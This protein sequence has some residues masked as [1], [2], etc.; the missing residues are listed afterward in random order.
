MRTR[1]HPKFE[2]VLHAVSFMRDA[3]TFFP[4]VSYKHKLCVIWTLQRKD[5]PF[6]V[7]FGGD[8]GGG[9]GGVIPRSLSCDFAFSFPAAGG[10]GGDGG[11]AFSASSA[12]SSS[13]TGGGSGGNPIVAAAAAAAAARP[14]KPVSA[15]SGERP[16]TA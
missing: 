3:V 1:P 2:S 11:D 9:G 5:S 13:L 8:V 16:P 12:S 7:F 4:F 14:P 6:E 15:E 10:G